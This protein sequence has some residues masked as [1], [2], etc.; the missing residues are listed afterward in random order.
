MK[1]PDAVAQ[2]YREPPG[3]FVAARNRLVKDLRARGE[4]EAAAELAAM[5]RPTLSVWAANRLREVAPR[6]LQE[7]LAAGREL[8]SAQARASSGDAQA[9]R[10]FR[11]LL[12][13]HS[14]MLDELVR[15]AADFLEEQGYSASEE[16]TRRLMGTLRTA[17]ADPETLGRQLA[18]GRLSTDLEPAGFEL[19][20]AS[21][22]EPAAGQRRQET[23][24][25]AARAADA[26]REA[27]ELER[28]AVAARSRADEL[29]RRARRLSE[30]ARA[31]EE[32]AATAQKEAHSAEER[33]AEARRQAL[34]MARRAAR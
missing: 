3:T 30:E 34:E 6:A 23:A 16:V 9:R 7:L 20:P 17:S 26:R 11:E 1:S 22:V 29:A 13:R 4:R 10:E 31:A 5:R 32:E 15:A 24:S 25:A 18:E 14:T 12:A 27:S 21:A 8:Q 28:A 33:A 2:L 19:A